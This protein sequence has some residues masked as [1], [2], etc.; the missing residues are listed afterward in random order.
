[1]APRHALDCRRARD[2]CPRL[3]P[4]RAR[5]QPD[6]VDGLTPR[7]MPRSTSSSRSC[8]VVVVHLPEPPCLEA[9]RDGV[10]EETT[11]SFGYAEARRHGTHGHGRSSRTR[12]SESSARGT[13]TGRDLGTTRLKYFRIDLMADAAM[14]RTRFTPPADEIEV[15]DRVL[16]RRAPHPRLRACARALPQ[17]PRR[18]LHG[19]RRRARRRRLALGAARR[20]G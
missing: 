15:P 14:T 19:V 11:V 13:W 18:R 12:S 2:Q 6:S 17:P 20:D 8:G 3:A 9:V 4:C 16:V 1:M 7:S 5:H 10:E